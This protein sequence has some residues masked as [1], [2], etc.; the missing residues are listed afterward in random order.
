MVSGPAGTDDHR[1]VMKLSPRECVFPAGITLADVWAENWR[2]KD[3]VD[4]PVS[5]AEKLQ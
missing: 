3:V 1:R 2:C 4:G 5:D